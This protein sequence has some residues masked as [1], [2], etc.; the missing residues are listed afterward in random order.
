MVKAYF[1]Y[2]YNP[3]YDFT[4][5]RFSCYRQ[6]QEMCVGKLE[7]NNKDRVLCLGLGTG[8]EI[9]YILEVNNNVS[10]TGVDYSFRALRKAK[11]K[12][13]AWGKEIEVFIMDARRLDFT[14]GSFDKVVCIHV[15][16]FVTEDEKV[17]SE[18]L[19]VLKKGGQFVITYPSK[20]E[21]VSLG[22]NILKDIIYRNPDSGWHRTIAILRALFQMLAG[23]VYLP[24]FLRPRK[25]PYL[26][27][28]LKTMIDGL[29]TGDFRIEEY[30]LYQD[31]IVYGRK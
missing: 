12:A 16:D 24:L 8:N 29:K 1:N 5:G 19:R 13:L 30:P 20:K 31:Y 2:V 9:F 25:R 28:E 10:I 22:L 4:T 18:I 23:I 11:S 6:L 14:S 3:V 7:L 17:T 21:G 27:H 15:M 26:S